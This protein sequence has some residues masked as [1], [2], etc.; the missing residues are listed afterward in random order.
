MLR[1]LTMGL[2]DREAINNAERRML[3]MSAIGAYMR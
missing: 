1:A 3:R 2:Q